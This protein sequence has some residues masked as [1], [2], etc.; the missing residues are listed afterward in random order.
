MRGVLG[1]G[2]RMSSSRPMNED[3]AGFMAN[4]QG[5]DM[6]VILPYAK[7]AQ[8]H[9]RRMEP[10]YTVLEN[11]KSQLKRNPYISVAVKQERLNAITLQQRDMTKQM[12]NV[13]KTAEDEVTEMLGREFSFATEGTP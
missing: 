2:E 12:F 11:E 5:T 13:I 6:A 9:L 7:Q 4:L 10:K 3:P 1:A 8:W